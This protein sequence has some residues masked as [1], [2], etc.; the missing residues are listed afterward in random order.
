MSDV[1]HTVARSIGEAA[2]TAARL[3]AQAVDHAVTELQCAEPH[4]APEQRQRVADAWHELL[5]RRKEW[6]DR[7]PV[8]LRTA[9]EQAARNDAPAAAGANAEA[10]SSGFLALTLVD[11]SEIARKIESSRLAQQLASMLERPLAEL[12]ALMSSALGL[13]VIQPER[14]PLR[15]SVY[16]RALRE[17]M[18][19]SQ[20]DPAWPS[21]WLRHM[22]QPIA[23]E[24]EQVYR[25]QAKLLTDAQVHAADY[26]TAW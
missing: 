3:V 19:A 2:G 12:D 17:L 16:A 20:P 9:C 24:L 8:L 14:N 7:F 6:V 5:A 10:L 18:D 21:L 15:P 26:R 1:S 13:P 4:T 22:V 25:E 23:H 11:D